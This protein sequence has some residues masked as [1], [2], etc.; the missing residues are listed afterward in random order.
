MPS[1]GPLNKI[2]LVVTES[3]SLKCAYC[4]ARLA[5]NARATGRMSPGVSAEII[6][7]TLKDRGECGLVQF[8]GGEPTLNLDAIEATAETILEMVSAGQL[9][10][11]PRLSIVT[12]GV[13]GNPEKIMELIKK[14]GIETTISLDG[15][16]EIHN[17]LRPA[18]NGSATY[19]RARAAIDELLMYGAPV[20]I[21]S[22]YTVLH[23]NKGFT[24]VDL[25][26]FAQ[27]LGVNKLVFEPAYPPAPSEL[28]PLFDPHLGKLRDYYRA[29]VDWW[30]QRLIKGQNVL[31]LYF[32]DVLLPLLEGFPSA[33]AQSG[34]LAGSRDITI[35]PDGDIFVCHLLYGNPAYRMG[36]ILSN[37]FSERVAQYPITANDID[38]CRACFA[39]HWCQPCAAINNCWGDAWKV[40]SRECLKRQAVLLRIGELAFNYL[41]VPEN[42]ITSGLRDKI[43]ETKIQTSI[44]L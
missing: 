38:S 22:V 4:Y 21:E 6:R 20:T 2:V 43:C 10:Q 14:F 35:G 31:D 16:P 28:N 26:D 12:N 37:E 42:D 34:C 19:D 24:I 29:G 7:R 25:L 32:K 23:M 15:P 27:G 40:A 39:H 36:N 1:H 44:A 30:F 5:T 9:A 8:F 33:V 17:A 13:W 11:K 18:A 41:N 3:C